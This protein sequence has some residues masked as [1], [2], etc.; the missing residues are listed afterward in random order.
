MEQTI[1]MS[2]QERKRI[3]NRIFVGALVANF[4]LMLFKFLAGVIGHSGAML[5]DADVYKRQIISRIEKL[6]KK[7]LRIFA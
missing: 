4:V 3:S 5:S 2:Q 7:N 1:V 6:V